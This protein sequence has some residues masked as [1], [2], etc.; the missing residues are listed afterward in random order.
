M[1]EAR[2]LLAEL[3]ELLLLLLLVC[4]VQLNLHSL[5]ELPLRHFPV[6]SAEQSM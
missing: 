1:I 2:K 3:R 6:L 4:N 5:I